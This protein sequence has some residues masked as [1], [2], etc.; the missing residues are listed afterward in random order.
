MN[1]GVKLSSTIS[2]GG[3]YHSSTFG[4]DPQRDFLTSA[5]YNDGLANPNQSWTYD[6]AENRNDAVCDNLNR[7]TMIHGGRCSSDIL[8]NR[9]TAPNTGYGWDCLNWMTSYQFNLGSQNVSA[10][11][12]QFFAESLQHVNIASLERMGGKF[13]ASIDGLKA[14]GDFAEKILAANLELDYW[15]ADAL[16]S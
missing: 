15:V 3:T 9:L 1:R 11:A 5:S 6:A 4:Y 7:A 14:N 8:G 12:L 13:L 16:E 2:W 10:G